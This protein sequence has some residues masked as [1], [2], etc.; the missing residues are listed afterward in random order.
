MQIPIIQMKVAT[1]KTQLE[2]IKTKAS[3]IVYN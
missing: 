3:I 2:F 1:L